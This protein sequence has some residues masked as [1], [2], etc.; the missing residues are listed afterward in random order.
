MQITLSSNL[1]IQIYTAN[2]LN[3]SNGILLIETATKVQV[4][5]RRDS[6]NQSIKI[7]Q[8]YQSNQQLTATNADV[9]QT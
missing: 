8:S 2:L 9:K 1:Y 6:F 7:N 4:C 3:T 5:I